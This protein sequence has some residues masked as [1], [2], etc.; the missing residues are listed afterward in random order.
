MGLGEGWV[1]V[2]MYRYV[3]VLQS[4]GLVCR[5]HTWCAVLGLSGMRDGA[6]RSMGK[7]GETMTVSA[8][9]V[10]FAVTKTVP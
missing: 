8:D 7:A 9:G 10:A 1:R 4:Q 2:F 6:R 3:L 5:M